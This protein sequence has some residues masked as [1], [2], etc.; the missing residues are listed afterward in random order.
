MILLEVIVSGTI[1]IRKGIAKSENPKYQPN[2]D[3]LRTMNRLFLDEKY[4][5]ELDKDLD[6]KELQLLTLKESGASEHEIE[7]A[8]IDL[9]NDT[10]KRDIRA[11][12]LKKEIKNE[13]NKYY[14]EVEIK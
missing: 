14:N 5:K 7:E 11:N 2:F 6:K 4:I 13:S 8:G 3:C 9:F 10:I 1:E 12:R